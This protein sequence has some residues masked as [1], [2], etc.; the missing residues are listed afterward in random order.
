MRAKPRTTK[1]G[2]KSRLAQRKKLPVYLNDKVPVLSRLLDWSKLIKEYKDKMA[3][4]TPVSSLMFLEVSKVGAAEGN[5][6]GLVASNTPIKEKLQIRDHPF[7]KR[8]LSLS[9][10]VIY[11]LDLDHEEYV[12]AAYLANEGRE[13]VAL[14]GKVLCFVS[15]GKVLALDDWNGGSLMTCHKVHDRMLALTC[16]DGKIRIL[17]SDFGDVHLVSVIPKYKS[18]PKTVQFL[19]DSDHLLVGYENGTHVL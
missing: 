2:K 14:T 9:Q 6:F 12:A 3:P 13:V 7:T 8:V 19:H 10:T 18:V 1:S 16:G 17:T 15:A 11:D 4:R 5:S